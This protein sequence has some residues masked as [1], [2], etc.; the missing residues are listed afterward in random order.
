MKPI[1]KTFYVSGGNFPRLKRKRAYALKFLFFFWE[2]KI[3]SLKLKIFFEVSQKNF[4]VPTSKNFL[5]SV[6]IFLKNKV[7]I[8][9]LFPLKIDLYIFHNS[10]HYFYELNQSILLVYK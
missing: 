10:L 7:I 1:K 5:I 8:F 9:L 2:M 6:L 4:K 3:F